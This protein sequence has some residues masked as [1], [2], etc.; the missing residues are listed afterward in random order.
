M[1]YIGFFISHIILSWKLNDMLFLQYILFFD[2]MILNYIIWSYFRV[3]DIIFVFFYIRFYYITLHSYY[4]TRAQWPDIRKLTCELHPT[5][6]GHVS[7]SKTPWKT[8][9]SQIAS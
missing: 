2:Y 1:C 9:S 3:F 4:L 7:L 8:Q 6:L 5:Y